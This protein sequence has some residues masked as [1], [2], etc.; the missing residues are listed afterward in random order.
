[1]SFQK[2]KSEE[3]LEDYLE[4]ILMLSRELPQVRSIDLANKLGYSKASISVALKNLCAKSYVH[5]NEHGFLSLTESGQARA[6]SVLERHT[7]LSDWLT[8]LGVPQET[9]SYDAC[10]MEHTLSEESFSAIKDFLKN[11]PAN[12]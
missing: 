1:M 4:A 12:S 3:S 2:Q 10:R 9:A 8:A 7:I 6:T 11:H 5:V